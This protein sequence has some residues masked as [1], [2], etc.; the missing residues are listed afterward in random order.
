MTE[1]NKPPN[2]AYKRACLRGK[3]RHGDIIQATRQELE[4]YLVVLANTENEEGL[5]MPSGY[6][7]ETEA[8]ATVI[9]HLL[10]V[11]LGEE[12]HERSHRLSV[13]AFRVSIA[14]AIF[15]GIAVIISGWETW[16]HYQTNRATTPRLAREIPASPQQPLIKEEPSSLSRTP[17]TISSPA[18]VSLS[19]TNPPS[20]AAIQKPASQPTNEVSTPAVLVRTNTP[21]QEPT[22]K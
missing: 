15:A 8:F 13:L 5:N 19:D 14:A 20:P 18:Q 12:L 3:F 9:R 10:Q 6:K 21:P 17:L 11:R 7:S 22:K 2:W 1:S 16:N 4:E